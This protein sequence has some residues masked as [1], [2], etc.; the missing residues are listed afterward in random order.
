MKDEDK[1]SILE[2]YKL[3][4]HKGELFWPDS[5]Y[6]DLLI[7]LAIFIVLILLATFSAS[8]RTQG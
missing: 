2:R 8:H 5:I 4:L 7:S 3:A 1:K 6:K